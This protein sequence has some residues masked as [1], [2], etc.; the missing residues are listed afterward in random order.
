MGCGASERAM[1][2]YT[3]P[4]R[5]IGETPFSMTYG[6]EAMIPMEIG[7]CSMRVSDFTPEKNNTKLAN[8]LDLLEER[9]E[10]FL[11]R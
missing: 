9:R 10:M 2:Y 8:D 6:T 3:T 11:I 4:R 5:S 1:A 7:L